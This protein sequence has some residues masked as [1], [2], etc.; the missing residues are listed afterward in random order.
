ME[1]D[2]RGIGSFDGVLAQKP[3]GHMLEHIHSDPLR[4]L[5]HRSDAEIGAMSN[6]R[7]Q[8][9][10]IE[11]LGAWFVSGERPER[12]REVRLVID[13]AQQ[14]FDPDAPKTGLDQPAQDFHFR[15]YGQSIANM[16]FEPSLHNRGEGILVHAASGHARDF[17]E[18]SHQSGDYRVL[19][20]KEIQLRIG[21]GPVWCPLLLVVDQVG[22]GDVMAALWKVEP[23]AA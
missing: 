10:G 13:F 22:K 16:Q 3:A 18:L 8:Q 6:Q 21:R 15:R 9:G 1:I 20:L 11:T 7:C 17:L 4:A 12:S 23:S 19:F 5:A 2:Q 14:I